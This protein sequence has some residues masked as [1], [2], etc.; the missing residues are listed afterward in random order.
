MPLVLSRKL[1]ESIMLG[2]DIELKILSIKGNKV[3]IGISCPSDTAI[4][5]GELRPVRDE[6]EGS[7]A[8]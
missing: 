2:D 7:N 4:V 3:R 1:N 8:A 6:R 5:R